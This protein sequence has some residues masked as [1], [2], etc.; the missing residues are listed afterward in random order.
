MSFQNDI[1]GQNTQLYPIVTI[2]PP[3]TS[4][5]SPVGVDGVIQGECIFVSTNSVTLDHIHSTSDAHTSFQNINFKPLLLNIP[6][7]K[8]SIDIESRKFKISNVSLDISNIEYEGKR[9]TN[10]F[11]DTS[12]MN[13]KVSIQF[14][15]PS[16]KLF[17]TIFGVADAPTYSFE[18]YGS[19]ISFYEAY[20]D[21]LYEHN[22]IEAKDKMTQM[23]YQGIIRR[24]SH[25]DTKCR[26]ELEDLTEKLAHKNLPSSESYITTETLPEKYRNKPKPIVYGNVDRSPLALDIDEDSSL[27]IVADEDDSVSYNEDNPLYI[28]EQDT[29]LNAPIEAISPYSGVIMFRT[30]EIDGETETVYTE[31]TQYFVNG[32]TI[33]LNGSLNESNDDTDNMSGTAIGD[34]RIVVRQRESP[35]LVK[36][37]R[38]YPGDNRAYYSV[39]HDNNSVVLGG[40]NFV[41][42]DEVTHSQLPLIIRGIVFR[43][44]GV[45][46]TFY[47]DGESPSEIVDDALWANA[48]V[49]T[50]LESEEGWTG[51]IIKLPIVEGI[52]EESQGYI[53]A[54]IKSGIWNLNIDEL[55][56]NPDFRVRLGGNKINDHNGQSEFNDGSGY[57]LFENQSAVG[58]FNLGGNYDPTSGGF[59]G[60]PNTGNTYNSITGD[61]KVIP[62][63]KSSELLY[64]MKISEGGAVCAS[65]TEFIDL[66]VEHWDLVNGLLTK[67]FYGNVKGRT[68]TFADHPELLLSLFDYT[69]VEAE[70][71]YLEN[72]VEL[73]QS[74]GQGGY[75][76]GLSIIASA[77]NSGDNP[78]LWAY[79]IIQF[80]INNSIY[81]DE[82][83]QS[84]ID[85][86]YDL[87]RG[88]LG[89]H[90]ID[91]LDYAEAKAQHKLPGGSDWKFGFTVNKKI[92][93][94]KLIEDIAKSTKCFPKFKND[95]TFGFNTIKDSYTCT[96]IDVANNEQ[97]NDYENA[98][99]IKESEVISYSFKKTKLEQIYQKIDVQYNKD[100]AQGS[101]LKRTGL[102]DTGN[103]FNPPIVAIGDYYG[104]GD[105]EP[106][107]EFESDYIRDEGTATSLLNFLTFQYTHPHLLFSLKLPLQY[108][109]LEVGDLVK[110][111]DLFNGVKAYGIDYRLISGLGEKILIGSYGEYW[112]YA[113][114]LFMITATTKNLDS[115]SIECMQLHHLAAFSNNNNPDFVIDEGWFDGTLE[116]DTEGLFYFPD[117]NPIVIPPP[118]DEDD[119]EELDEWVIPADT[120]STGL[121]PSLHIEFD[122][123]WDGTV[124]TYI[125][126]WTVDEDLVDLFNNPNEVGEPR[127][128]KIEGSGDSGTYSG[129]YEITGGMGVTV[130]P[131]VDNKL[132]LRFI[133]SP[134]FGYDGLFNLSE[135]NPLRITEVSFESTMLMGDVNL[136]N[137]VNILDI[138]GLVNYILGTGTI[139]AEYNAD[140]NQDG[141]VNILDI[142]QITNHILD[143]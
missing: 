89:H 111:R 40:A 18:G 63:D 21:E 96:D 56:Y 46:T 16:A 53:F 58:Q 31:A 125:F 55:S 28:N 83:I 35:T 105:T 115:V 17:S 109:N 86:I 42:G 11:S 104:L 3:N 19:N 6:S 122:F 43:E 76:S 10:I 23:V 120:F 26:V 20:N 34:N 75:D 41:V 114:P 117:S 101:Y 140:F 64:Y 44:A 74:M 100:Y 62:I 98:H 38:T 97:F 82:F 8:E 95:G 124:G 57:V 65:Q 84:P 134:E 110:F 139:E 54:N 87:V 48:P 39:K 32:N 132:G 52:G 27:I 127:V 123:T 99:L 73:I 138:V 106:Y 67:D 72:S 126:D 33:E 49:P 71:M 22:T 47:W 92:N 60:L 119:T 91:E 94:K 2:E 15:S 142:V 85:I 135:E 68:N 69:M 12:L 136:D 45:S 29:F 30:E 37:L 13:W 79:M 131:S 108:I 50:F 1:Q 80:I 133:N 78:D 113:Y 51:A 59:N 14:V 143:S 88:E 103:M 90:A 66:Y 107:L 102:S 116:G 36:A 118:S 129:F 61:D 130:N 7:I 137:Q 112:Q 25:D 77:Y 141:Q 24:I 128:I 70:A 9:F 81:G 93:S 121:T 5:T 4:A